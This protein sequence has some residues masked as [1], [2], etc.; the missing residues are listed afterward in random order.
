MHFQPRTGTGA[1]FDIY[2]VGAPRFYHEIQTYGPER[3]YARGLS[4]PRRGRTQESPTKNSFRSPV[5]RRARNRSIACPRVVG[6]HD[7]SPSARTL[8]TEEDQPTRT[9]GAYRYRSRPKWKRDQVRYSG[10]DPTLADPLMGSLI[11]LAASSVARTAP[12]GRVHDAACMTSSL[13]H[14]R[15]G[16]SGLGGPD[17]R[18]DICLGSEPG[19]EGAFC[20]VCLGSVEPTVIEYELMSDHHRVYRCERVPA[21]WCGSLRHRDTCFRSGAGVHRF[22]D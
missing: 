8:V 11:R 9:P 5:R 1:I 7:R 19:T 18:V 21:Y 13:Q 16:T 12:E 2:W 4:S 6:E 3:R 10:I 22:C 17:A 20:P 15:T 14:E